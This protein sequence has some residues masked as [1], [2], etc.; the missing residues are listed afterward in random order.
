MGVV[1]AWVEDDSAFCVV[2]RYRDYPHTL[3]V[4]QR[5]SDH[6][7]PYGPGL[8]DPEQFGRTVATSDIG[9][10]LGTVARALQ[11]DAAGVHWWG[12]LG[13]FLPS[14]PDGHRGIVQR[15]DPPTKTRRVHDLS[16]E[17]VEAAIL[18]EIRYADDWVSIAAA[19]APLGSNSWVA[20]RSEVQRVLEC[21]DASERLCLGRVS[22]RFDEV[23]E[24]LPIAAILDRIFSHND[25]SDRVFAM[26]ELFIAPR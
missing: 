7:D 16:D 17:A 11:P 22:D 14:P 25:R 5:A 13:D 12:T 19:L 4:R 20:E 9:E 15:A 10:P 3:G 23:P 24:P 8:D 6:N 26:M 2:Y 18:D 21:V 1:D